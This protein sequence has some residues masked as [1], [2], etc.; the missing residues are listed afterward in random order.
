MIPLNTIS[1]GTNRK[2]IAINIKVKGSYGNKGNYTK[3]L[4]IWKFGRRKVRILRKIR[5]EGE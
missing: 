2:Q 3:R 4:Q 1:N 5:E